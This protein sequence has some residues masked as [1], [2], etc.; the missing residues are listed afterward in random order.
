VGYLQSKKILIKS[1]YE[2]QDET[3]FTTKIDGFPTSPTHPNIMTFD[4][5]SSPVL[6]KLGVQCPHFGIVF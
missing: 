6:A 5:V 1:Q 4:F 2:T 3:Q